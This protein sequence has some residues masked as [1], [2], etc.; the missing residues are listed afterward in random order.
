MRV[1]LTGATGFVGSHLYPALVA[2]GH[3]VVCASRD[4]DRARARWPEQQW[5]ALDVSDAA[6]FRA[7]LGGCDAAFYLVHGLLAAASDY[8]E[9][10]QQAASLF[11]RAA[12]EARLS[13]VVYLGGMAPAGSPSRHL[14]SRLRT[15]QVLREGRVPTI[16]LRASM[17]IGAGSASWRICRDLALRLP[18]MVLP[19]WLR[20]RSE[21][22]SIEDVVVALV[23]AL[24]LD[25]AR[26]G[27]YDVPGP[28]ILSAREILERIARLA[29]TRPVMI[30]VPLV[31]P[32]L[33]A[34][35][36]RLVTR[37]DAALAAELVE[38]L[39]N[40][41]LS[42]DDGIWR[43]LPDHE[44]LGFDAAARRALQAEAATVSTV[45]QA[46]ER[47]AHAAARKA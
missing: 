27:D 37:T 47:T 17:I 8:P 4:P 12:E 18:L 41:I 3:D 31:T 20:S 42:R 25:P 15:G 23:A 1:L 40:D 7:P 10:E 11:A 19:R 29:G 32:H 13:K 2:A 45:G 28:E 44:R 46:V 24:G 36:I 21:P 33:S 14:A 34:Y 39:R 6:S 35:W 9:R 43:L 16:E 26:A 5:R 22:I 30:N 38:G